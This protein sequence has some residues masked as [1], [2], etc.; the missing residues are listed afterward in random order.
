MGRHSRRKSQSMVRSRRPG[1]HPRRRM[2]GPAHD[3]RSRIPLLGTGAQEVGA[4]HDLGLHGLLLYYCLPVVF[5][6]LLA[7]LQ[8]DGDERIYWEFRRLRPEGRAG[9]AFPGLPAHLRA[10]LLILPGWFIFPERLSS[11]LTRLSYNSA[12][13]QLPS[14]WEQ[15]LS[16]AV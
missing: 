12:L 15:S 3:P 13:P 2:Y 6:G 8:L 14:S 1:V 16:E 9:K 11:A 4:V 5:L 10:A 7:G